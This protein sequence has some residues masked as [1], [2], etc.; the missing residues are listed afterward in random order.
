MIGSQK[1]PQMPQQQPMRIN[2]PLDQLEDVVC[3]CG[4]DVFISALKFKKLSALLSQS[5]K[6]EA[7][8]IETV[9]CAQCHK[10]L[11]LIKRG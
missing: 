6:E 9:V 11:E 1:M 7:A 10:E 2:V 8:V 3:S 4:C 5:G